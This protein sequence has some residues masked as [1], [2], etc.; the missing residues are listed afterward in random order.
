M[1]AIRDLAAEWGMQEYEAAA[2]LD[3]G[4]DYDPAADLTDA[5]E[6]DYRA[7]WQAGRQAASAGDVA[8]FTR[9]TGVRGALAAPGTLRVTVDAPTTTTRRDTR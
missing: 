2:M 1:T 3:L 8:T 5:Q 9:R 7:A 6:Q 4:R